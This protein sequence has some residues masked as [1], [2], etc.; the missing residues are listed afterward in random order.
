MMVQ[1]LCLQSSSPVSQT[2]S[3]QAQ[4]LLSSSQVNW[5]AYQYMQQQQQQQQQGNSGAGPGVA[6]D[7]TSALLLGMARPRSPDHHLAG[8][9]TSVSALSMKPSNLDVRPS[10][11]TRSLADLEPLQQHS[12]HDSAAPKNEAAYESRLG[13]LIAVVF[14]YLHVWG[15]Q[16]CV[17]QLICV[18]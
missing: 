13:V 1:P 4:Q 3:W 5:L 9:S 8:A 7:A 15:D 10:F 16:K 14:I 11:D 17:C 18:L 2:S 6:V 12:Y